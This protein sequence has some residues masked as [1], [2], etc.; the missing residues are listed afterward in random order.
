MDLLASLIDTSNLGF[1]L[2]KL[3]VKLLFISSLT[4]EQT[5]MHEQ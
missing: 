3:K 2:H 1:M 4:F 5:I